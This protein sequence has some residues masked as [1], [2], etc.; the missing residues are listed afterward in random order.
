MLV[1]SPGLVAFLTGHV[2]PA[3]LAFPSRD[4]RLEKPALALVTSGDAV[5]VA[6]AP[7][8]VLGAAV[9]YGSGARGL[10]DGPGAFDALA[11]IVAG[12]GLTNGRL[13]VELGLV[14]AGAVDALRITA[15]ALE[16]VPLDDLLRDARA[17]KSDAELAGLREAIALCDAGQNAVRAA[18]APGVS[19]G[20]LYAAAVGAMIERAG[21]LVVPVGEIQVGARGALMMGPPTSARI[22]D[23]DLAMCD[24][25]PRHPNGWWGDSCMTAACGEPTAAQRTTWRR[26]ADAIEAGRDRLRPGVLASEVYDAVAHHAGPQPGHAGH[27]I[28]RDHYEEPRIAPDDATPLQAGAVIVLEPG[29]YDARQGMRIEHAFRVTPKG[30]EPLSTFSLEL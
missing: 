21:E 24:L 9:T 17:V 3:Y 10:C 29:A 28:G 27:S 1:A 5:T 19:E 11:A 30:G 23:G 22:A 13:A 8:P 12:L 14:P 15:P 16:I 4:G 2:V 7:A 25:A 6:V 18:V 26:L 20:D